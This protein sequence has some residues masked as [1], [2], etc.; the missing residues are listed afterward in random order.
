MFVTNI[1]GVNIPRAQQ[2]LV[3]YISTF[4]QLMEILE[5][6]ID[7]FIKQVHSVDSCCAAAQHI[8][9]NPSMIANLKVLSYTLKDR[10]TLYNANGLSFLLGIDSSIN[11]SSVKIISYRPE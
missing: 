3:S 2:E 9:Y 11:V 6:D 8:I 1:V 7:E 5:S 4:R 10:N